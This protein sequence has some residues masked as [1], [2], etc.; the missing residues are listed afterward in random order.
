MPVAR[1]RAASAQ[2]I[3]GGF[4]GSD[5][6]RAP[7]VRK[8]RVIMPIRKMAPSFHGSRMTMVAAV[9]TKT[10]RPAANGMIR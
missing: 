1:L 2:S 6:G 5:S 7:T 9:M 10:A 4:S 8:A 3:S